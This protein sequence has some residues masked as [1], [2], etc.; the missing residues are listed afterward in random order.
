MTLHIHTSVSQI[1][2]QPHLQ[3][4][5]QA[6]VNPSLSLRIAQPPPESTSAGR[7]SGGWGEGGAPLSVLLKRLAE[8]L[9]VLAERVLFWEAAEGSGR[10]GRYG[11][12][13]ANTNPAINHV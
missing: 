10:L 12:N 13:A 4:G 9:R 8:A 11:A 1:L 5:V 6:L 2:L 7:G 3:S